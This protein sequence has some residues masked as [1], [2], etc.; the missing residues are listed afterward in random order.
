MNVELS[1]QTKKSNSVNLVTDLLKHFNIKDCFVKLPLLDI[2]FSAM[3]ST[4]K[5]KPGRIAKIKADSTP[6]STPTSNTKATSTTTPATTATATPSEKII[7]KKQAAAA[8][9]NA[10]TPVQDVVIPTSGGRS[11]RT[12]KPNP[13]YMNDT[14]V[15]TTKVSIK[16]DSADSETADEDL[17]EILSSDEYR[18]PTDLPPKKR[19]IHKSAQKFNKITAKKQVATSSTV[20]YAGR[21]G[22]GSVPAKRKLTD[23][24][25][26]IDDDHGKQLF[27]AAKR[28]L[29]HVS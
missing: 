14:V 16:D 20:G 11:R 28:R 15:N 6:A 19:G 24:D 29:T 22:S 23:T 26:D 9:K 21:K 5:R 7:G 27:L 12:P 18:G 10:A 4:T 25:I 3:D 1:K 13:R 8:K 17:D 2:E